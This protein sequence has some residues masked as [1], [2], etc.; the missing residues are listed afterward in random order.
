MGDDD[1]GSVWQPT[2]PYRFIS[3][4]PWTAIGGVAASFL[5]PL[6]SGSASGWGLAA[7]LAFLRSEGAAGL[8]L[9]L[10]FAVF[11]LLLSVLPGLLSIFLVAVADAS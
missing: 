6:I 10:G 3:A 7:L 5:T 2:H 11:N 4:Y 9:V 8:G 1:S